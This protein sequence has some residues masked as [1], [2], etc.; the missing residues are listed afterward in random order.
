MPSWRVMSRKVGEV[1]VHNGAS[2]DLVGI[3][4][5][6]FVLGSGKA[7]FESFDRT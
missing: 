5:G 3:Q 1:E 2:A 4:L 6:E 7:D